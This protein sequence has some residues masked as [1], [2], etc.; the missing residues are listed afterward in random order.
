MVMK[1]DTGNSAEWI[2]IIRVQ[3]G[4]QVFGTPRLTALKLFPETMFTSD[5]NN[6]LKW[7]ILGT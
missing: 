6:N 7:A 2:R 5:H 4:G 3:F 1:Y